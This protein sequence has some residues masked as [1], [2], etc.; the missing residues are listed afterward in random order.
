MHDKIFLYFVVVI[1]DKL[2]ITQTLLV[3][4]DINNIENAKTISKF[5]R[6]V[7][8]KH[9]ISG[10]YKCFIKIILGPSVTLFVISIYNI[11]TSSR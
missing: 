5:S 7:S 4:E 8:I 6:D 3:P 2:E 10:L 9:N 11:G 1:D